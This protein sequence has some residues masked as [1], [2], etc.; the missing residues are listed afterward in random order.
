MRYISTLH[1]PSVFVPV[2]EAA[3]EVFILVVGQK[4]AAHTAISAQSTLFEPLHVDTPIL[5]P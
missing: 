4:D 1:K 2:Y 3:Q 5:E